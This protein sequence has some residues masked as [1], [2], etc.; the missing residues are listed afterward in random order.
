MPLARLREELVTPECAPASAP[1]G[2]AHERVVDV[3]ANDALSTPLLNWAVG[4]N[5]SV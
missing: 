1:P 5:V 2:D 4:L 3:N